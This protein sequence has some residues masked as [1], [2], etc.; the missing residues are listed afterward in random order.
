[1]KIAIVG[2]RNISICNISRYISDGAEIV[3]GGA[4]PILR[5]KQIVDCADKIIAFWD[6]SSKGTLSVIKYAKKV[7]KACEII[8]CE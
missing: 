8:L 6:G 3:S 5:N 4:A 2:S 1:M 7:G